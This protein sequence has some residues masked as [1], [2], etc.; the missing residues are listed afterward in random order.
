MNVKVTVCLLDIKHAT[1]CCEYT[2]Q[3]C[4][5][6]LEPAPAAKHDKL[7]LLSAH[8]KNPIQK[9]VV[10]GCGSADASIGKEEGSD[11]GEDGVGCSNGAVHGQI[12]PDIRACV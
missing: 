8:L 3:A 1:V 10:D 12:K 7:N 2:F 5:S 6:D 4:F 9:S 11:G